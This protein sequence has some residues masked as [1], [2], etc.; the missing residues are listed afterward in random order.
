MSYDKEE[1]KGKGRKER[2]KDIAMEIL[3]SHCLLEH[4]PNYPSL[5][6]LLFLLLMNKH[7]FTGKVCLYTELTPHLL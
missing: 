6:L 2:K 4:K 7:A 3:Y 1:K 5:S